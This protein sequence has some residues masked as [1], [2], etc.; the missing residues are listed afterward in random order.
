MF[1]RHELDRLA[2]LLDHFPVV[3]ILGPRQVGKTTL[4]KA[5]RPADGRKVVY[6]DCERPADA[7]KLADPEL[8]FTAHR[9]ALIILDE[10][11]F[12]PEVF[13]T[14]RGLID[15]DR[16]PGRFLVLGSAAPE[17]LRQSADTLAGRI[18]YLELGGLQ[19]REIG[20]ITPAT[21]DHIWLRG[22]FP[23]SV[24]ASDDAT[25]QLWR[26]Q[27]ITTYLERDL[28]A[29]GIRM[30]SVLTRRFWTMLAHIHGQTLNAADLAS[31]LGISGATVRSWLDLLTGL[32]LVRQLQPWST[33]TG[34]RQVKAPKILIRDCGLLHT[35]LGL[36]TLDAV[37]SHPVCGRSWEGLIIEQL[38][39]ALPSNHRPWFYAT[40]A[41]SEVDLLIESPR[42]DLTLI[43][44]KRT[45]S[46]TITRG[47]TI[48]HTDLR[49][50]RSLLIAP[51]PS[52]FPLRGGWEAVPVADAINLA[53]VGFAA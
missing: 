24:T 33:N 16:R 48:A 19:I 12:L 45:L 11:Q 29:Q 10:I 7:A 22:G 9:E 15:A 41:G 14:L 43:E 28:P 42:G 31:G 53:G 40:H 21:M 1:H 3:G 32:F 23:P 34:K 4:A 2:H 49:P 30:P 37:L 47:L 18:A 27:F 35:L 6:L 39:L 25:S 38:L 46:P 17:L 52:P 13:R 50:R 36:P 51:I 20:P 5:L 44:I 8:L 26:E